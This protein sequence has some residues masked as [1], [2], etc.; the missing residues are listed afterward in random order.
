ME[1]FNDMNINFEWIKFHFVNFALIF[2]FKSYASSYQFQ[3]PVKLYKMKLSPPAC[4]AMMIC[5]IHNVPV[6]MIDVDLIKRENY[7]PE[8]LKVTSQSIIM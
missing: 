3:M 7:T 8:F 4:A 6:E 5:E 1:N 2:N